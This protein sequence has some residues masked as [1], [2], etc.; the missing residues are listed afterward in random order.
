MNHLEKLIEFY[1][2]AKIYCIDHGYIF[3]IS[4]VKNRK[5][6]DVTPDSFFKAFVYVVLNSGMKNQVAHKIYCNFL[7][8]FGQEENVALNDIKSGLGV[9]GHPGKRQAINNAFFQHM[10][11]FTMLKEKESL[12]D[13]LVFLESLPWIGPITRY[14]LARNL[15]IDVAKPDR[16]MMRVAKH[17]GYDDV[18]EMC[19]ELSEQTA[20]RIGVVDIIL[21]RFCSLVP[22]WKELISDG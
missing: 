20:D 1:K 6:E 19:E 22:N 11:W 10:Q 3:E 13:R 14:H 9:I 5:F 2:H 16:H 4:M 12:D 8:K 18:Q 21:W 17:F 7:E 15:G